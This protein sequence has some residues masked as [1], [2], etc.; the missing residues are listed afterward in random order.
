MEFVYSS[1]KEKLSEKELNKLMDYVS[2]KEKRI[3]EVLASS[4]RLPFP[5]PS[6]LVWNEMNDL[7][8]KYQTLFFSKINEKSILIELI[9]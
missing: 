3:R 5:M 4:N 2:L 8:K 9:K 1:V 7:T 6:Q